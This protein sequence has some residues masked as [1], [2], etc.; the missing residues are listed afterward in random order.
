LLAEDTLQKVWLMRQRLLGSK[1]SGYS[2]G[3][4]MQELLRVLRSTKSD[5]EFL[6]LFA[7]EA[8]IERR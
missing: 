6:N 5:E 7:G 3:Q 1:S 4:A 8:E 2:A